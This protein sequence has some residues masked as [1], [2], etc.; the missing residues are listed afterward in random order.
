MTRDWANLAKGEILVT[1]VEARIASFLKTAHDPNEPQFIRDYFQ[2]MATKYMRLIT[3]E[4][5]K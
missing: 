2:D 3:K 4:L 1:V 5:N